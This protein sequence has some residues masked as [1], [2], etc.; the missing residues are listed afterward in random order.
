MRE[1]PETDDMMVRPRWRYIEWHGWN[2]IAFG[3]I[4]VGIVAGL[5]T[6]LVCAPWLRGVHLN[7]T[8]GVAVG[9]AVIVADL[10]CR[11]RDPEP[12]GW[13]RYFSSIAG[14]AVLIVPAWIIGL[15][16]VATGVVILL[17]RA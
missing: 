10:I 9:V 17:G 14:G 12:T 8:V 5:V 6:N 15:W 4:A 1:K 13:R 16:I 7:G 3:W 2:L 11:W